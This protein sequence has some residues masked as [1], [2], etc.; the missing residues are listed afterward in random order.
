MFSFILLLQHFLDPSLAYLAFGRII[1]ERV[2][3]IDA[4]FPFIRVESFCIARFLK[5]SFLG[6]PFIGAFSLEALDFQLTFG[7][8]V[9]SL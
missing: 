9:T 1:L 4:L 5:A 3:L 2:Y 7:S 6:T 8:S